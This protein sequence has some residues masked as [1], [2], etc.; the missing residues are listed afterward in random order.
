MGDF[1][2][3]MSIAAIPAVLLGIGWLWGWLVDKGY[4]PMPNPYGEDR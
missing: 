3:I 2:L 1:L 4:L